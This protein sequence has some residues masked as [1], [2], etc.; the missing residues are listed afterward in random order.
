MAAGPLASRSKSCC[1]RPDMR[2]R[3]QPEVDL[4]ISGCAPQGMR[5]AC[6]PTAKHPSVIPVIPHFD[7]S[8]HTRC[9]ER[10]DWLA[11]QGVLYESSQPVFAGTSLCLRI[12][13]N[14][15]LCGSR[16]P[17]GRTKVHRR[18]LDCRQG[19]ALV[20][21]RPALAWPDLCRASVTKC[22][23]WRDFRQPSRFRAISG[24]FPR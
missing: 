10:M 1:V 17:G 21:S 9:W 19:F 24:G 3:R 23:R 13:W 15:G 8:A 11:L 7:S 5:V 2:I 20:C 12:L 22:C 16:V 14:V 6:R 4:R 18:T